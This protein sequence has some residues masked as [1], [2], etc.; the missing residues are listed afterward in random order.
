MRRGR[1]EVTT[2]ARLYLLGEISNYPQLKKTPPAEKE[3]GIQTHRAKRALP[4]SLPAL[5][6]RQA[7]S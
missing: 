3:K 1:R 7:L 2:L 5:G 4:G 6:L